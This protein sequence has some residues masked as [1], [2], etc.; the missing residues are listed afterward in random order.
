MFNDNHYNY[1]CQ[2]LEKKLADVLRQ[3]FLQCPT[4]GAQLLL[5]EVF[6]GISG[7]Q[8]VQVCL[9]GYTGIE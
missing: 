7:R 8:L 1:H 4:I 6:E 3:S 5:L 2:D 9:I